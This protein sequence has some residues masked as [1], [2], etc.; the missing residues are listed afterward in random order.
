MSDFKIDFSN[1]W[2]LLLLI[3]A[4]FFA[5][6]PYF[7][8]AKKYRRTRNRVISVTLHTLIMLLAVF[9]LAGIGFSYSRPNESNELLIL[10]DRS[11]SSE[12]VKEEQD[13]F[14][15]SVIDS[16][17]AD[18]KVGIVSY[19]YDQLYVAPLSRNVDQVYEQYL[20]AES[21]DQV[22]DDKGTDIASALE[23]A[24][25]LFQNPESGKI[26]LIS[27]GAETDGTASSVIKSI[28]AEG[29]KIDTAFFGSECENE[30]RIVGVTYPDYNI[31]VGDTFK[32]GVT[33]Q[34]TSYSSSV[35]TLYDN[36]KEQDAINVNLIDGTQTAE[37]EYMFEST[38]L[39]KISFS[40]KSADDTI[41]ENNAY[42]SY[43]YLEVFDK[44]LIIERN[45]TESDQ[46]KEILEQYEIASEDIDHYTIDVVNVFDLE[47]MPKTLDD[48]RQYDQVILYNIANADM[49]RKDSEG[50]DFDELLNSYVADLGGGVL[51]IGG[52]KIDETGQEVANT[53]N[54]EDMQD[55]NYTLYQ[56]MLPVQA[57]NYTPPVGVMIIIDRSGSMGSSAGDGRTLLDMAKEGAYACLEVLTERDYCGIMTL[58]TYYNEE[59]SLTPMPQRAKIEDAIDS[60]EIGGGTVFTGAIERAGSALTALKNVAKRHIILVTDGQPADNLW[61]NS[62]EKTG[63]YGGMIKHYHDTADIT[64]SVITLGS[65][66]LNAMQE[67]AEVGGGRYYA[68]TEP[69]RLPQLMGDDLKVDEIKE[70]N[71]EKFTPSIRDYTSVVSGINSS[72]MPSLDG[73]YGTK[74]KSG[75]Q[76]PLIGPYD[77]PIYAQWDY[78]KGKV[79]SFMCDLNGG[80]SAEFLSSETGIRIIYN[81]I[82]ALFPSEDVRVKEIETLLDE[83]NFTTQM[84]IFTE[85][86]EGNTITVTIKSPSEDG[87]EIV[88]TINP[89]MADGFSRVKF[90]VMQPGIHQILVEKKDAQGNVLASCISYKAFSYS[91]EYDAF[92][93]LDA[94]K[95]FLQELAQ[96]GK[97]NLITDASEV[98]ES[99]SQ[100]LQRH[101][102]PR[103]LFAILVIVLFVL[104]VA[105][106]KF[107]FKWPHELIREHRAEKDVPGGGKE[108]IK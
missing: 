31:V 82:N 49:P 25:G 84:S 76:I 41:V 97:G 11:Y 32:I 37:F 13:E 88:Q 95:L 107:K 79:G 85:M 98:F 51:T 87:N 65:T 90:T 69:Q 5:F 102:D 100:T 104:D 48:L 27:D 106:R 89:S 20:Q 55:K 93:D 23:Y 73:Y 105:V 92:L 50:Y 12:Q 30:V 53:Y 4:L 7:R 8:I 52:N 74:I 36:D 26:L 44:I 64:V 75:A 57:I 42:Y 103:I 80:W 9:L 3:P 29:I 77:V 81:I 108:E 78:G 68:V 58:E 94:C 70:Y 18:I 56:Q 16:A 33:I 71:P 38:G 47:N 40:I 101:Y 34:S 15:R 83:E 45:D 39:H 61:D 19:G 1:P 72:E 24:K 22:P 60:I 43:Y 96:D 6:F 62:V 46:L 99:F 17:V 54:R 59:V 14:I 91:K 21:N 28:A 66:S 63:G 35:V 86:Q 2:F 10:V 67:A